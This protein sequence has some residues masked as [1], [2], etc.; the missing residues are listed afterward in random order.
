MQN[1]IVTD[2][3]HVNTQSVDVS[4]SVCVSVHLRNLS[5]I[6]KGA[7]TTQVPRVYRTLVPSTYGTQVP[8]AYETLVPRA[9]GRLN[10]ALARTTSLMNLL[11][12]TCCLGISSPTD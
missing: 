9:Y 8:Q 3:R 6:E 4:L 5:N 1:T 11:T 12:F 10:L 2:T 7:Y